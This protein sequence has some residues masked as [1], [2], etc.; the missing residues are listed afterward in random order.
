[1]TTFDRAELNGDTPLEPMLAADGR[2]LYYMAGPTGAKRPH[3]ATRSDVATA[4][5][6]GT[7]LPVDWSTEPAA[8][9]PWVVGDELFLMLDGA[10]RGF[11]PAV[12]VNDGTHWQ[13]PTS[14]GPQ[15]DT[16]YAETGITL[17]A[18]G[19][20]L[21]FARNDGPDAFWGPTAELYEASRA[22][23][24]APGDSF[25]TPALTQLP[26]IGD[27][28]YVMCPVLSP[29]GTRLF[30]ATSFPDVVDDQN[31]L[32]ALNVWYAQ[33]DDVSGAWQ[34]PLHVAELDSFV[35]NACPS[36]VSADGCELWSVR[37]VL[38]QAANEF[39]IARRTP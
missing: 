16:T 34:A 26:G 14:L 28:H 32:H 15:L 24:V 12:S 11:G 20:R 19:T 10:T 30:F 36:A 8:G 27:E 33:R 21:M 9:E 17:S 5:S 2:T 37:F 4:F 38:G 1:M 18:D 23:P 3:L 22:A 7:P 39:V 25:G 31:Y 6:G 29:D 35:A 13:Q